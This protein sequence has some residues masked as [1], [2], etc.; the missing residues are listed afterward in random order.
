MVLSGDFKKK[1]LC[2]ASELLFSYHQRHLSSEQTANI[3]SHL[4]ACDFCAA[5]L[6][7]LVRFPSTA[8]VSEP[9]EMP[10]SLR[11]LAMALM[12]RDN[13]LMVR[14]AGLI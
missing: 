9:P 4:S 11:A 2:P 1:R 6:Q 8:E 10:D 13:S 12:R 7:L 3:A 5:E 14:R